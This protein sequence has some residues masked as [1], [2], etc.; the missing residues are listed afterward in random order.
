MLILVNFPLSSLLLSSTTCRMVSR[1]YDRPPCASST[2]PQ[3]TISFSKLSQ[4]LLLLFFI[5]PKPASLQHPALLFS[6]ARPPSRGSENEFCI[7]PQHLG[8][9]HWFKVWKSQNGEK[10]YFN[11][12]NSL[13]TAKNINQQHS[14]QLTTRYLC[15]TSRGMLWAKE[16]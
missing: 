1:L 9:N 16:C 15:H 12:K 7:L 13:Q 5:A 14:I 3:L 2:S 8:G 11:N 4:I 10:M 6:P